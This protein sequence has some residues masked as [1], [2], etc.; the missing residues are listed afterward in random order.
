M[1]S[2]CRNCLAAGVGAFSLLASAAIRAHDLWLEP[3]GD[4]F[5]LYQGHRHSAHAGADL[6]PYDPAIVKSLLCVDAAG[7]SR[8]RPLS[9]KYPVH[10][11][12]D[13]V[14]AFVSVSSGYWTK[15]AWETKNVPKTQV[16]AGVVKSWLSEES[17]KR[18]GKW[19]GA[20]PLT[21]ALEIV[22][23]SDPATLKPGDKLT[24]MVT[25][26]KRPTAGVPVAYE[27]D[28][29]GATGADGKVA[30]RIRHGGIQLIEASLETPLTDGKADTLIRTTALQFELPK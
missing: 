1:G 17:L 26:H 3:S 12:V 23:M 7:V 29:R 10:L 6:V 11:G 4:G 20:Q 2:V 25:E 9:G 16:S 18:L 22:P 14:S 30:I 27:G 28:T 19:Q 15:T 5:A 13:C 8:R 24:V 21:D